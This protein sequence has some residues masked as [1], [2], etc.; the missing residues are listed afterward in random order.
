MALPASF[1][2]DACGRI[3]VVSILG[4]VYRVTGEGAG[5]DCRL[6]SVAG[7]RAPVV[8]LRAHRTQA[9]G[10]RGRIRVAAI[11]DEAGDVRVTATVVANGRAHDL[12]DKD[13]HVAAGRAKRFQWKLD[14]SYRRLLLDGHGVTVRYRARATDLVGNR[15][16]AV[17]RTVHLV[18]AG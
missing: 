7:E 8:R 14:A 15:S 2:E 10:E 13:R 16:A 3:Y 5:S 18:P 4:P 6:L 1:G 17:E 11:S 9:I 12:A